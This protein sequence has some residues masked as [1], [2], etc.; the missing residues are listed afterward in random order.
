ML[1]INPGRLKFMAG[2]LPASFMAIR[3]R[4]AWALSLILRLVKVLVEF[5]RRSRRFCDGGIGDNAISSSCVVH[6]TLKQIPA[7]KQLWDNVPNSETILTQSQ[8]C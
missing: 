5:Q 7:V 4:A 1:Q 2:C 6:P 3:S 8:N